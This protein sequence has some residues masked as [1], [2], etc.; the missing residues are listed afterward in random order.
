MLHQKIVMFFYPTKLVPD[1][2]EHYVI[3]CDKSGCKE[4]CPYLHKYI[5][6]LLVICFIVEFFINAPA[7]IFQEQQL[8]QQL[9]QYVWNLRLYL[10]FLTVC[11][12]LFNIR[13]SLFLRLVS[14][15]LFQEIVRIQNIFKISFYTL[16]A[17]KYIANLELLRTK[18]IS[19]Y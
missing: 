5:R 10:S 8:H 11:C 18:H 16:F 15:L 4:K 7:L 1:L 17:S 12:Q 13:I 14:F 6:S 9:Q 2:L 19:G 3:V